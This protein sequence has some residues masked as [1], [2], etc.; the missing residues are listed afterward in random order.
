[1]ERVDLNQM[2][3]FVDVVR[4]GSFTEAA[5]TLGMPKSTVSK[6]VAELEDRLGTRLLQRTT[7]RVKLTPDGAA[8]Y[9]QCRRIVDE[10]LEV[11]RMV[12]GRG[13]QLRGPIRMTA[14]WLLGDTLAPLMERFLA[15][16]PNVSLELRLSDQRIDLVAEGFDLAIRTGSLPDSSLVARRLGD[17]EHRICAN[18]EYLEGRP[19]VRKPADLRAHDCLGFHGSTA[20]WNFERKGERIAV[21]VTGRYTV[22]SLPLIRR[23]ALAG[24]GIAHL[25]QFVA[26]DDLAA[27]RLVRL[28]PEW[29]ADRGAVHLVYPSSRNLSPRVRALVDLLAATFAED[30][31]WNVRPTRAGDATPP[32]E[33][34][35]PGRGRAPANRT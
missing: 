27:G 28:L 21:P 11:D 7:R 10:A 25:P 23:A 31:P 17:V 16:H 14:P 19:A 24:L 3:I 33:A 32:P 35:K 13:G 34:R 1:V 22:S 5:K 8:Y 18:A 9:E 29:S 20:T 4:G 6:R 15:A 30:R 2:A 12:A 26:E